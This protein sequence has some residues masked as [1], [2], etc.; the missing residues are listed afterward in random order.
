MSIEDIN[1]NLDCNFTGQLFMITWT[2]SVED[3]HDNL[4]CECRGD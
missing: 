4:D 1:D 2:V 3:I